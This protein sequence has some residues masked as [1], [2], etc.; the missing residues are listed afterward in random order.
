MKRILIID[1]EEM[2]VDV[3]K[4][5]LEEMGHQVTGITQ[6]HA[7]EKEAIESDYDLILLDVRMPEKNGAEVAQTI[8]E[9]KPEARILI[10]TG[11]PTD[12]LAERALNA[13]AVGLVKKPFDVGKIIYFL[14]G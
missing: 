11:Y 5:I 9:A 1:D 13:G 7:G 3:M 12:P 14:K 6:S 4:V 2:M 8:L 10:I